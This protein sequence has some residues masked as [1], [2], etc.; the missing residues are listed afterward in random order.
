MTAP[1]PSAPRQ[2]RLRDARKLAGLK[3]LELWVREQDIEA[4]RAFA[5]K[6]TKAK[7]PKP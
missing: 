2:S 7:E 5:A 3:R 1:K 4:I 6:R